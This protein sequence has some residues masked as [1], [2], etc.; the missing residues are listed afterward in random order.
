[1]KWQLHE[2]G[3]LPMGDPAQ[4]LGDP[5]MQGVERLS[6]DLPRLVH[7]RTFRQESAA[8]LAPS[9]DWGAIVSAQDHPEIERLFMLFSYFASAYVHAP[10]L[11]PADRLPSH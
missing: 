8:Y 11:P 5:A 6:A 3:F 7:E 1:M 2:L 9:L 10:G 4:R